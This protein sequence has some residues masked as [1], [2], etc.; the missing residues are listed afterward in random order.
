MRAWPSDRIAFGGDY[1]PEQW[2]RETWA[3]D[4][5]L[6]RDAGVSF[7]TLGV[8]SWSWLEPAPGEYDFGWLDEAMDLLHEAGVA[9]DLATATATPPPWLSAAHPEILPVDHDGHTLWPGS[10][11][12]WCPSSPVYRDHALALT[13]QLAQR[14]H[15][16]PALALWHVSNEYA[17]HNLPCYCDTCAA[18]FRQWLQARYGDLA[19][20][21]DA[22]GTA[23]WSQRYTAWE[24]V[25]PPRRTTTIANPTHQLDFARYGSDTLLD[26]FRAEKAV[27]AEHSPGVP[28]TT[29]FMTLTGFRHLDYHQWA[30]EQDVVSTD[31]YVID[32]LADPRAELAFG[33]DLTRGLAGGRP[34]LLMEHSTSAVNWQAVNRAKAPGQTIRDS[35]AHVARG[36]DTIGFFQWRQSRA[37]AEKFHSA[38]VPHAGAD[39]ARFREVCGL[40][41][42]ARRLGEVRGSTVE[43]DVALLWDYQAGWAANGPA[44]PSSALEYALTGRAVHRVLR[45]QGVTADVVHPGADLS[46]YRVIV[47]PTLYLV[48]DEHAAAVAAAAEAGAQ[49]LVTFF[50]GISDPDDHVRLGGYPGAFRDLLGV[51]VEELYPLLEGESVGLSDGSRATLWSEDLQAVDAEVLTTYADGPLAGQPAVTR[52]T[53]GA[54]GAWYLSTLPGDEAL[55]P[56]LTR[57]LDAAGV[58]PAAEV[59]AGV[60]AVRR[61]GEAGSWLFLLNHT[62]DEQRVPAA[63]H[64]LV[65]DTRVAGEAVLAPGGVAVIRED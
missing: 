65:R 53:T 17:C 5:A 54:G 24:Q 49:V 46:G 62:D 11:Q 15:D 51:R 2:P 29:N 50:S 21:N 57:V 14:Y 3:Q 31:H 58:R 45:E 42:L 19:R 36:A 48:S 33:A 37:G 26:F 20:L 13:T 64:D 18:G 1:N 59:P 28:V 23:F 39:T 34:W 22:W 27:L 55:A 35:L 47:V 32:T 7:V 41:D 52:R 61:R 4:M 25:L 38:V 16:H 8:F 9:V 43:A 63:G 60:D 56:L 30:P 6:M 40:G 44:M 12:T 10:R